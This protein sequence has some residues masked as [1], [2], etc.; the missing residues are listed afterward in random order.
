MHALRL[1]HVQVLS[2]EALNL[3][4]RLDAAAAAG[5]AGGRA[6]AGAAGGRAAAAAAGGRAAAAAAGGRAAAAAAGGR[7][8]AAAARGRTAAGAAG[9]SAAAADDTDTVSSGCHGYDKCFGC[10]NMRVGAAT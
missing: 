7:A 6:A 3:M 2:N 10:I 4:Q 8:A 5:A 1:W 9:A